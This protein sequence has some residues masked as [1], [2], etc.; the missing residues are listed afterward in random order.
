MV[1][2]VGSPAMQSW[3]HRDLGEF[4]VLSDEELTK[5]RAYCAAQRVQKAYAD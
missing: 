4:F 2:S 5:I 3:S 1:T